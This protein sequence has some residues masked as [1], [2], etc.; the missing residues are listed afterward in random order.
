MQMAME[1]EIIPS[2]PN[3]ANETQDSM[4]MELVTMEMSSPSSTISSIP[5][6][7][8]SST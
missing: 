3:D 2:F 5:I 8:K 4:E 7:M 1:L 6:M